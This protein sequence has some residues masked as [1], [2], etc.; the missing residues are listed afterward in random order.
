MELYIVYTHV[1]ASF[2]FMGVSVKSYFEGI[3]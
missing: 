2:F 3:T 1:F